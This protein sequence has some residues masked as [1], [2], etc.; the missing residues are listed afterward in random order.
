MYPIQYTAAPPVQPAPQPQQQEPVVPPGPD[1]TADFRRALDDPRRWII[2]PGVPI[3]KCHERVDPNTQKLIRVDVPK[4]YRIAQN[5]QRLERAGVPVRMTLGH[6]EPGKP[7]VQQPPVSGYYRNPRVQTFGPGQEAAVVV[8][9]WL[10][11]AYAPARKNF[12]YRSAEYF[13]DSE[14][15]TGVALLTR[16]PYLDLGVVAYCR[17][18]SNAVHYNRSGERVPTKYHYLMG[19][20]TMW[21]NGTPGPNAHLSATGAPVMPPVAGYDQYGQPLPVPGYGYQPGAT[22]PQPVPYAYPQPPTGYAPPP[23]AP[24]PQPNPTVY[25]GPMWDANYHRPSMQRSHPS[26]GAIYG[27]GGGRGYAPRGAGA[28]GY[29]SRGYYANEPPS[30][31]DDGMEP[32]GPDMDMAP[33]MPPPEPG[34]DMGPGGGGD[35]MQQVAQ[36]LSQAAQLIAQADPAGG[37]AAPTAPFPPGGEDPTMSAR[38]G[39]GGY[40]PRP[41]QQRRPQPPRGAYSR[42]QRGGEPV[43]TISG[44]PVGYQMELQRLTYEKNRLEEAVGV[45]YYERDQADTQAC[46]SEIEKLAAMGYN[47]GEYEVHELK[48]KQTPDQ[49]GMYIQHILT[50]YERVGT[51]L[52]P[53]MPGD[54]TPGPMDMGSGYQPLSREGMEAALRMTGPGGATDYQRAVEAVR[55]GHANRLGSFGFQQQPDQ[56]SE[57][58]PA[59]GPAPS[60]NGHT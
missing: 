57:Y 34:P 49:R 8:D 47:V 10:D 27:R 55:N 18:G 35:V 48:S 25:T 50:K 42:Y 59:F 30:G 40:R 44:Y 29:G 5:M 21:P 9:E 12:P 53:N 11:P 43:R 41:Q 20:S 2:K 60:N 56:G 3:F 14:Q 39:R 46:I 31:T 26:S 36:L 7:E 58:G 16:D 13:D 22:V 17:A 52:P 32:G 15:I 51:D 45:L 6:T 54:P 23:P 28:R 37:G 1:A 38:Y 33:P 19:D 24:P 4:L